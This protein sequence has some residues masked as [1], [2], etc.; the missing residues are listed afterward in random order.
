MK[1]VKSPKYILI[2]ASCV[3]L[4]VIKGDFSMLLARTRMMKITVK[5]MT[6]AFHIQYY[7]ELK[8]IIL[9]RLRLELKSISY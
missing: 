6:E 3:N 5:T 9:D 2:E 7:Q 8:G 1:K 4:L